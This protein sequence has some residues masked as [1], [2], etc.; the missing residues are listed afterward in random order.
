[1]RSVSSQTKGSEDVKTFRQEKTGTEVESVPR[2]VVTRRKTGE[3]R[4]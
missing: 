1:M 2:S 4:R 3:F